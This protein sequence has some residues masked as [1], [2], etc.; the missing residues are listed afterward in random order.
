MSSWFPLSALKIGLNKYVTIFLM[1]ILL[2]WE[3]AFIRQGSLKEGGV[4]KLFL[5]LGGVFIR[6]RCLKEK[7]GRVLTGRFTVYDVLVYT[8]C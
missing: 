4:H 1:E 7:R 5:I 3:G 2:G 8:R 6:G